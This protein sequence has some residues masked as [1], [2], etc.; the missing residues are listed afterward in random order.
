MQT[1]LGEQFLRFA[2]RITTKWISSLGN[3]DYIAD[4]EFFSILRN[5]GIRFY[6]GGVA[7]TASF[8]GY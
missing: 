1:S 7:P 4:D 6:G 2:E 5:H 8:F 3:N